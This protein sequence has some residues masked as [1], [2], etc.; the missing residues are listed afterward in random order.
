M[1]GCG[2][3]GSGVV[4]L[5][6][7]VVLVVIVVLAVF[8]WWLWF[9]LVLVVVVVDVVVVVIVIGVDVCF[10]RWPW[11]LSG[12]ESRGVMLP[13]VLVEVKWCWFDFDSGN[14]LEVVVFRL[15]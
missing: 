9:F 1:V 4:A 15:C 8:F 14:G 10:R 5:V 6:V 12:L 3:R 11:T 13:V 7:L 2:S